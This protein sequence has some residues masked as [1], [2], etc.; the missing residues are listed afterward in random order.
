MKIGTPYLGAAHRGCNRG[1][2]VGPKKKTRPQPISVCSRTSVAACDVRG[3]NLATG[4]ILSVP[5]AS[6]RH[7][8][9]RRTDM[10]RWRRERDSN[11]RYAFDVYTLSRRAPST[12]RPSLRTSRPIAS[13]GAENLLDDSP[14]GNDAPSRGATVSCRGSQAPT[15]AAKPEKSDPDRRRRRAG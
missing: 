14:G 11:P 9:G 3:P 13:R 12:A 7:R 10:P 5:D 8:R 1:I 2:D 4:A 15:A 6:C